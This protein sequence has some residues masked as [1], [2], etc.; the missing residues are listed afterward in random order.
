MGMYDTVGKEQIQ[1]K[2]LENTMEHYKEGSD[3]DLW[4]GLYIGYEGW[5]VVKDKKVIIS[6]KDIYTKW[7]DEKSTTE[8]LDRDN[9]VC[10]VFKI[11]AP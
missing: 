7:G 8:I 11:V 4:D 10:E 6:G 1:I 5:F 2:L 9:P 3:I